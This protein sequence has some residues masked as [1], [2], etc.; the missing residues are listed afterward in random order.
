MPFAECG[1]AVPFQEYSHT[2][3]GLDEQ[4][5][6]LQGWDGGRDYGEKVELPPDIRHLDEL[7]RNTV[8]LFLEA[9]RHRKAAGRRRPG[10]PTPPVEGPRRW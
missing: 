7:V 10:E 6:Y 8:V 2:L 4:G 3:V 1:H 9:A 5:V